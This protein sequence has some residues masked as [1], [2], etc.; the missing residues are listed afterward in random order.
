[1]IFTPGEGGYPVPLWRTNWLDFAPRLGLAWQP[2]GP[3][4]VIRAGGGIFYNM[5]GT[6]IGFPMA[7]NYPNRL[8]QTFNSSIANPI[9][10]SNPFPPIPSTAG[11]PPSDG[12]IT[13][14][15]VFPDYKN[16]YTQQ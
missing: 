10:L 12:S 14:T 4:T 1:K 9:T 16:A 8:A 2:L 15:G 7:L 5:L 3:K 13:L 11:A 6:V